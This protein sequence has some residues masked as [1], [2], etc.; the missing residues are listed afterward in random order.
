[1]TRPNAEQR[2]AWRLLGRELDADQ[3]DAIFH[4]IDAFT[5]C[6]DGDDESDVDLTR[7]DRRDRPADDGPL[8]SDT[9]RG[10]DDVGSNVIDFPS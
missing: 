6:D 9:Q 8:D 1:M 7:T 4:V 3:M 10:A 5:E 2:R